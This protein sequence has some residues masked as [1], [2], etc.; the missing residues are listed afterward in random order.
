M[1]YSFWQY[2]DCY[3][4]RLSSDF[5]AKNCLPWTTF[6]TSCWRKSEDW[7]RTAT[8]WT[9]RGRTGAARPEVASVRVKCVDRAVRRRLPWPGPISCTCWTTT[10][11]WRIGQRLEG[12]WNGI[13]RRPCADCW[14]TSAVMLIIGSRK[15][16]PVIIENPFRSEIIYLSSK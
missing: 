8:M 16:L 2:V 12:H 4:Q 7:R 3:N 15:L 10:R 13:R 11:S 5:R 14:R 6:G 1:M 9:S